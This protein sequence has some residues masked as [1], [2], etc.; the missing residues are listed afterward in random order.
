MNKVGKAIIETI[1]Y[2]N[3]WISIGAVSF[4]LTG[5][6]LLK[7]QLSIQLTIFIFSTTLFTYNFQRLVK[8]SDSNVQQISGPRAD[9]IKKHLYL[10]YAI[11]LLG[12]IG[13]IIT[14]WAFFIDY[15]W[16][17]IIVGFF[18]FFYVWKLPILKA[19][20]RSLP[21]IKIFVLAATW[22]IATQIIPYLLL[23]DS[24]LTFNVSLIFIAS[25]FFI[26]S[27]SIPFDIRDIE[28][29]DKKLKTIPQLFGIIQSKWIALFLLCL[30]TILI[31]FSSTELYYGLIINACITGVI[32][33]KSRVNK[34]ELYYSGVVDGTLIW[35]VILLAIFL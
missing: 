35:Q 21:A 12:F 29:D 28:I 3:I 13:G 20:I 18:S 34:N 9:W 1:V 17:F 5:A 7:F 24:A 25:F 14:G 26:I 11:T 15:Y 32:I 6:I 2:S 8:V 31:S 16:L 23:S 19:N 22:I 4:A 33:Y 10:V 27:I 30:S